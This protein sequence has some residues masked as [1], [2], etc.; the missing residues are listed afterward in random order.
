MLRILSDVYLKELAPYV[1]TS[2]ILKN[3]KHFTLELVTILTGLHIKH[4]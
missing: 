2:L 1:F 4:F 3:K